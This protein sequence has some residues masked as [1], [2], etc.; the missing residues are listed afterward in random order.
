MTT[1]GFSC[2]NC[3]TWFEGE[4]NHPKCPL[5]GTRASPRDLLDAR[6]SHAASF[7]DE[8]PASSSDYEVAPYFEEEHDYEVPAPS[9][10]EG[11]A[12]HGD[13]GSGLDWSSRLTPLLGGLIFIIIIVSRVCSALAE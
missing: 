4:G 1:R 11:E 12:P 10:A 13:S 3:H 2:P 8:S 5:C 7:E 6:K 9:R